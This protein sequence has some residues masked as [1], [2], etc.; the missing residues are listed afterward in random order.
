[1]MKMMTTLFFMLLWTGT[2]CAEDG[3]A[4]NKMAAVYEV[5]GTNYCSVHSNALQRDIGMSEAWRDVVAS[6]GPEYVRASTN[7]PN[8]NILVDFTIGSLVRTPVDFCPACRDAEAAWAR[9]RKKV[10]TKI[11]HREQALVQD[12]K[13]PI[14]E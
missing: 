14:S 3:G 1:M 11:R 6:S 5:G 13:K 8:A 10:T 4:T 2:A 12:A 7:F 9:K